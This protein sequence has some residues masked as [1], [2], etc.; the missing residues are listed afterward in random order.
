M[1]LIDEGILD[2]GNR[3]QLGEEIIKDLETQSHSETNEEE[4]V[5][6]KCK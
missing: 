5:V 6:R 2:Q 3:L 4:N 1:F